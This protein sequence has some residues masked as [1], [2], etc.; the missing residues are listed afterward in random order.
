M[1]KRFDANS[2]GVKRH[3]SCSPMTPKLMLLLLVLLLLLT[4]ILVVF[5]ATGVTYP[6]PIFNGLL[7]QS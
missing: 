4:S 6:L 3:F 2:V 5:I 1:R 7:D